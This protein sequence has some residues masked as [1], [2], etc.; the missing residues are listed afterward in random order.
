M[1]EHAYPEMQQFVMY[2]GQDYS[3]WGETIEAIVKSFKNDCSAEVI[4]LLLDEMR[5]LIKNHPNDLDYVFDL[6]SEGDFD[7]SLWGH[8]A[9]SFLVKVEHLMLKNY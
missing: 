3:I 6:L 1:N 9:K 5:R 4:S 2:F 7:V 8:T